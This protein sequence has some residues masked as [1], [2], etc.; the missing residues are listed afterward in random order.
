VHRR[1]Q[2]P[3]GDRRPLLALRGHHLDLPVPAFLPDRHPPMSATIV[4]RRTYFAVFLGLV[5]LTL[6]TLGAASVDLGWLNTF[7][8]VTIATARALLVAAICMDLRRANRL[9]WVFFLAGVSWLGILI[10]LSLNDFLT[11]AWQPVPGF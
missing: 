9:N 7:A 5:A 4:P 1:P 2:R 8:A 6:A 3:G 11:R 10:A